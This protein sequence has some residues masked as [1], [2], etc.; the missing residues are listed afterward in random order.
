[1]RR[2]TR[3]S[4]L[5]AIAGVAFASITLI[6]C[7]SDGRTL[8]DPTPDQT[9]SVYTPSTTTT[10]VGQLPALDTLAPAQNSAPVFFTVQ[11]PWQNGGGIDVRYTCFGEDVQPQIGW[12]GVPAGTVEVALVVS[13]VD[14]NNFVHWVIAGLDPANP[15]VAENS[16]PL[17]AIEGQN[18]F[19]TAAVPDIGWRGPCPPAGASHIYRFTL[20]ALSQQVELPTGSAAADLIALIEGSAIAVSQVDGVYPPP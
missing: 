2:S 16:V 14:A 3:T 19:S 6:A 5:T 15:L 4:T 11:L 1:M 10:V 20:Y 9:Q 8:R 17:G 7:A 18:G 13:D 12:I